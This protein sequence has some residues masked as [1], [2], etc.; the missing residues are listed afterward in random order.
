MHYY[1]FNIAGWTLSTSHLSLVEEAI[2]FRL[3]N[4]YYDTEKPISEETQSVFRRL[5][6][7]NDSD[8]ANAVLNEFFTLTDRGWIQ[9]RC[10]ENLKEYRKTSK[11]NKANGSKGGRP[12]KGAASSVSQNKPNGLDSVSQNNPNYKLLT[13]NH[14][15]E[16]TN[17]YKDMFAV[18]WKAYPKKQSKDQSEKSWLKLKPDQT[19]FDLILSKLELFKT[20]NEWTK[21]GGQF[22]P[23]ASTW[24]NQKRW[25]DELTYGVID[26][27][28]N[29]FRSNEKQSLISKANSDSERLRAAI[30]SR[31]KNESILDVDDKTIQAPVDF[32][33]RGSL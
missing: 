19:L 7:G 5:R 3:I 10:E 32:I 28:Q 12:K 1:K 27:G 13:N 29:R 25:N 9:S 14:K 24:L 17:Q 23:N 8:I 21:D 11:K 26:N 18:F 33:G 6:M 20:S 30:E 31:R 2:Y 15:L 16:T 22:I 4:Y